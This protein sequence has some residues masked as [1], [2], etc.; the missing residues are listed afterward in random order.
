MLATQMMLGRKITKN[1]KHSK[2]SIKNNSQHHLSNQQQLTSK[3][4]VAAARK[5]PCIISLQTLFDTQKKS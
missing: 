5:K 4:T 1:S 3:R 2:N